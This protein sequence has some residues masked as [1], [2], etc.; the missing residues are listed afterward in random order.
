VLRR[1]S[2]PSLLSRAGI[3]LLL[4]G[5]GCILLAGGP[6]SP[7]TAVSS[8]QLVVLG[9][10]LADLLWLLFELARALLQGARLRAAFVQAIAAVINVSIAASIVF[11]IA[12]LVFEPR[13]PQSVAGIALLEAAA[14][15]TGL[16]TNHLVFRARLLAVRALPADVLRQRRRR[17]RLFTALGCSSLVGGTLALAAHWTLYA[18][19]PRELACALLPNGVVP[20]SGLLSPACPFQPFDRVIEHWV[21]GERGPFRSLAELREAAERWPEFV[22]WTVLRDGER[23]V[24]QVPVVE[25]STAKRLGRLCA[26]LLSTAALMGT[27]LIIAWNTASHAAL[28][29][30]IFYSVVSAGISAALCAGSNEHLHLATALSISVLAPAIAQVGLTFP[31]ERVPLWSMPAISAMH[32]I[33]A[34]ALMGLTL[35]SFARRGE[36]FVLL[37]RMLPLLALMPWGGMLWS[38]IRAL[39]TRASRLERSRARILLAGSAIV[40]LLSVAIGRLTGSRSLFSYRTELLAVV[41]L[42]LPIAAAM[43]RYHVFD[44]RPRL[45]RLIAL[46]AYSALWAGLVTAGALAA[47]HFGGTRPPLGDSGVLFS[48]LVV[49][50]L[51]GEPL[52]DWLMG[53]ARELVSSSARRRRIAA[54]RGSQQLAE[55]RDPDASARIITDVITES[56]R[57]RWVVVFLRSPELGL[58]P[59]HAVGEGAPLSLELGR[60]AD[61]LSG[62]GEV[63]HLSRAHGDDAH[64]ALIRAGVDVIVPLHSAAGSAG[65]VLLGEREEGSPYTLE[66]LHYLG[67]LAAQGAVALE[68]A[69]LARELADA[70]R[71]AARGNLAVGLAHELGKPLRV[72]EDLAA[73]WRRRP[74]PRARSATCSRSPASRG[75]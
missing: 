71:S 16:A 25:A 41:L 47:A 4:I 19:P 24:A 50:L 37:Q 36:F 55:L 33:A 70:E 38:A 75:T 29:F 59:A 43:V 40:L 67:Q 61:A 53:R 12:W 22:E 23:V 17:V 74:P 35:I 63:I 73:R 1:P 62:A 51:A 30:L 27:A 32:S 64:D 68:N 7:E 72:I 3:A 49:L 46:L 6:L 42:P 56:L 8:T 45:R 28:P 13:E 31:R 54:L 26:A 57:A 69:R 20:A 44:L 14:L 48:A 21:P 34:A 52:R 9:L 15:L 18:A 66:E 5:L 11:A 58:R 65:L 39:R 2:D 60:R 10:G